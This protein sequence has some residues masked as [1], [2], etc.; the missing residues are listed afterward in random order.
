MRIESK[1]LAREHKTLKKQFTEVLGKFQDFITEQ[2]NSQK[3]LKESYE[4]KLAQLTEE[5]KSKAPYDRFKP[6]LSAKTSLDKL[7]QNSSRN[8]I[9]SVISS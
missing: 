6:I 3:A 8:Q 9:Y 7:K 4:T 5:F 2:E 1:Q